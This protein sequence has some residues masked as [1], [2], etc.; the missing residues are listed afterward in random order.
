MKNIKFTTLSI[1]AISVL[2]FLFSFTFSSSAQVLYTCSQANN[3]G[4]FIHIVDQNT[5]ETLSST[6]ITLS[7]EEL[8]GC[9]GMAK[10]PVTG[11]CWI[12]LSNDNNAG[13]GEPGERILATIDADTGIAAQ[14]GVLP[15]GFAGLAFDTGGT[16][17]GVT[18]D[19][20]SQP[21]T[22]FTIDKATAAPAFFLALNTDG[23]GEDG[24]AIGFNP[25]D[26]LMYHAS[27]NDDINEEIIFESINLGTKN[28]MRKTLHG[29]LNEYDENT[30][31]VYQRSNVLLAAQRSPNALHAVNTTGRVVFIGEMDHRAK[32]MAFDCGTPG[33]PVAANPIPTLS[34]WGLIAMAGILGIVGFIVMRRRKVAA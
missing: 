20:A 7:G 18:G 26:G 33:F 24:E 30:A 15:N 16:L 14:I 9:T 23:S 28:I 32:G 22:L 31:L 8:Q 21:S 5:A 6:E 2:F 1:V 11:V 13:D 17:Y 4:P 3:G 27:G 19:G 29:Q 12:I 25:I 34:E 10:D